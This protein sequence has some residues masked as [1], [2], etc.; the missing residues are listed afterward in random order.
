MRCTV[1]Q[2][3]FFPSG[4]A[5][6]RIFSKELLKEV[7]GVENADFSRVIVEELQVVNVN[8]ERG[9]LYSIHVNNEKLTRHVSELRD[10]D[11][12][13]CLAMA[14]PEMGYD[15]KSVI[16]SRDAELPLDAELPDSERVKC[17]PDDTYVIDTTSVLFS[18][19]KGHYKGPVRLSEEDYEKIVQDHL[20]DDVVIDL[21]TE[22]LV[23]SLKNHTNTHPPD[24]I[25]SC[26]LLLRFALVPGRS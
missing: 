26:T 12:E 19:L 15:P 24:G 23:L 3:V 10:P 5:G 14:E 1:R 6:L 9:D 7:S 2:A 18:R 25:V 16:P 22:P 21:K 8:S 13:L 20:S 17:G 11:G 4:L